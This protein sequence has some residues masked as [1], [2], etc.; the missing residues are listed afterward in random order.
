M[1]KEKLIGDLS[2]RLLHG[3]GSR[4]ALFLWTRLGPTNAG[5]DASL[6]GRLID[7]PLVVRVSLPSGIRPQVK[8]L[9]QSNGLVLYMLCQT[10]YVS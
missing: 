4:A 8:G 3:R 2:W 5:V 6:H 1:A 10:W 7:I 9:P